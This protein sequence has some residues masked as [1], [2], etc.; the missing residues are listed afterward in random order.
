MRTYGRVTDP[1]NGTVWWV[2]VGPDKNGYNDSIYLTALCQTLKLNLGESPFYGDWGIPAFPSV[3]TQVPPDYYVALTQKRYAPYFLSVGV[4]KL[5]VTF[6][7]LPTY[8]ISVIF[9]SGATDSINVIPQAMVDGFGQPI[10]DGHGNPI[11]IGSKTGRYVA[12]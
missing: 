1:D 2:E 5:P 8:N 3:R 9:Q 6:P 7:P 10:V 4:V 11:S 12:Q